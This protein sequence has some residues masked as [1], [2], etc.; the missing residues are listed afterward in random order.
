M[1][2][3]IKIHS[4]YVL[5]SLGNRSVISHVNKEHF[6]FEISCYFFHSQVFYFQRGSGSLNMNFLVCDFLAGL[7]NVQN[8]HKCCFPFPFADNHNPVE[9]S[10][11]L[12]ISFLFPDLG[13][14]SNYFC[15]LLWNNHEQQRQIHVD[16]EL[17]NL[18]V[19]SHTHTSTTKLDN[20]NTDTQTDLMKRLSSDA[21][22]TGYWKPQ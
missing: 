21:Y 16:C 17:A 1:G 14:P 9:H 7:L 19:W 13:T 3:H 18:T 8:T 12:N 2:N 10:L 6:M 15:I 11:Y 5:F 20:R 22:W 4:L